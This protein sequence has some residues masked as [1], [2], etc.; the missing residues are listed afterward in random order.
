MRYRVETSIV[1]TS[2]LTALL[3]ALAAVLGYMETVLLAPALPLPGLRL[4]LANVAVVVVLAYLG[5][6]R[7]LVVT[8]AKVLIV[9]V[10][11]G[12]I[13]GPVG[14]MALFGS[15]AS[16]AVMSLLATSERF[17]VIGWSVAGAGANVCAQLLTA[18]VVMNSSAPLYLAPL[19]LTASVVTGLFVGL[20]AHLLLS[21]LPR[22]LLV[23]VGS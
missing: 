17:S 14:W 18:S 16:W 10:A 4:G 2:V 23:P 7:A 6:R 8:A 9:G 1:R 21:R 12:T 19:S 15:L 5:A 11:T 13:A 3:I 22:T 20:I